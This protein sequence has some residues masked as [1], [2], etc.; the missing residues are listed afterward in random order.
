MKGNAK[1]NLTKEKEHN[2]Y[3]L[4]STNCE[5]IKYIVAWNVSYSDNGN[6]CHWSLGHYLKNKEE[7]EKVFQNKKALNPIRRLFA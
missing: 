6:R 1:Y 3:T 7:A 4:F 2:N 5:V